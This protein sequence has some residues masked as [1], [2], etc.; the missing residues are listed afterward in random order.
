MAEARI[1]LLDELQAS[2][3]VRSVTINETLSK[4]VIFS[5]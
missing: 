3:L 5:P 1:K 2:D 4:S